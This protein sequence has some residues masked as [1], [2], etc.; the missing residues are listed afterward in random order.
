MNGALQDPTLELVDAY[1][2]VC[3][4]NN[5]WKT[6]QQS[7]IEAIG[8]QPSDDRESALVTTVAAGNYTAVVRGVGDTRGVGLVEVYNL[9]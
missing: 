7:E 1:G 3:C 2:G 8:I 4:A 9:R 6:N 5:D